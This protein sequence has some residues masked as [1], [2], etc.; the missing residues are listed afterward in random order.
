MLVRGDGGGV[1]VELVGAGEVGP[2]DGDRVGFAVVD[3]RDGFV[4]AERFAAAV[5]GQPDDAVVSDDDGRGEVEEAFVVVD[6]SLHNP[7]PL[8]VE[9]PTVSIVPVGTRRV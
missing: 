5:D 1:G 4:S 6:L 8:T 9:G 2:Q 3:G 7:N